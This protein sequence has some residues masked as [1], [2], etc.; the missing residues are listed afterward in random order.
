M[1]I[2]FEYAGTAGVEAEGAVLVVG[3]P[4][5]GDV[6]PVAVRLL[7]DEVP[8]RLAGTFHSDVFPPTAYAWKGVVSGPVQVWS[9]DRPQQAPADRL[10]VLNSDVTLPQEDMMPFARAVAD[11]AA[12]RLVGLVVSLEGCTADC[13]KDG[14]GVATNVPAEPYARKLEATPLHT[15]LTGFSAALLSRTNKAGVPAVGLFA[16]VEDSRQDALGAAA[17]LAA[18]A[19]LLPRGIVPAD[20]A[21]KAHETG[22]KVRAEREAQREVERRIRDQVEVSYV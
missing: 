16:P 18:M 8:M 12:A 14:V 10:L 3:M 1:P 5:G 13:V 6:G 21:K 22:Q 20:L 19:P 4:S 15:K 7:L 17:L 9:A 11:W 2:E